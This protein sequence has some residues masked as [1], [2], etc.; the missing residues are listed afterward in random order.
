MQKM[1]IQVGPPF[2][3]K[4]NSLQLEQ[5]ILKHQARKGDVRRDFS[6]SNARFEKYP[7]HWCAKF[8]LSWYRHE[9]INKA[10][11]LVEFSCLFLEYPSTIVLSFVLVGVVKL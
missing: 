11:F 4:K 6:L 7:Q 3:F 8:F 9:S 1:M 2:L 10:W 5:S